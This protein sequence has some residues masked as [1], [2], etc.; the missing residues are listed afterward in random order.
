MYLYTTRNVH[1]YLWLQEKNTLKDISVASLAL[2]AQNFAIATKNDV[3][4]N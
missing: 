1:F 4:T 2:H 3:V